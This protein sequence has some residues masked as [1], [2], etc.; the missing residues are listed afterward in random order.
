M[1]EKIYRYDEIRCSLGVDQFDNPYPG[2]KLE[3]FLSEY[4]VVKRTPKGVW[5]GTECLSGQKPRLEKFILLTAYKKWGC[6]TKEEAL[7]SF[8]A[9]KKKQIKML[10]AQLAQAQKALQLAEEKESVQCK[11]SMGHSS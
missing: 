2:Y 8:K 4:D 6:L 11:E 9:R 10:N 1:P 7:E 5:I 3:L